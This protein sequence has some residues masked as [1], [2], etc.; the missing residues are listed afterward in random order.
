[1]SV[2]TWAVNQEYTV[3][4]IPHILL[5]IKGPENVLLKW[6]YYFKKKSMHLII[7]ILY[8][9][10]FIYFMM[11]IIGYAFGVLYNI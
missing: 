2:Q 5:F 6:F 3:F 1:M 10:I 7:F 11:C 8:L 4:L 9:N